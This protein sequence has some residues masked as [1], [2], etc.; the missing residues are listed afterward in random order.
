MRTHHLLIALLSLV[1]AVGVTACGE[2]EESG[3]S[4][5]SSAEGGD[6]K[7][8]IAIDGSS[9]VYPFAQA[10]AELFNEENPDVKISVGQSG[11]G[12]GFEKFC[13]GRDR[14]LHRLAPDQGR[15]G[16]PG[17]REGGRLVLR[18]PDRQRRRRGRHQQG[19]EG[20]LPDDRPA[21]GALEQGLEG[22]EP[23]GRRLLAAR[24][25]AVALRAGHRLGHVRL[26]HRR[27]QRRGRRL[28][29]GLR[30]VRGRQPARHRR[31][32]RSGRPRLL[33]L[34]LLR[35]ERRQAQPRRH[36]RGRR[37][38]RQAERR[39]DPGRL[40]QAALAPAVH[41]PEREGDRSGPR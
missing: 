13:A 38:A 15:R 11:T 41:V 4:S 3:G 17:L 2:D 25:R 31:L 37:R 10:A 12:G 22:C 9:T 40:L 33:R 24:R 29:R 20:R 21:Q 16:G 6:L 23:Q 7:G 5:Q 39:D 18:G 36:R 28:A 34:L 26:L 8:S 19:P 35:A 30:G 14:R 32:G 27:D 1:L